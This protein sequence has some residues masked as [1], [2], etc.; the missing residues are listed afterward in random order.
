MAVEEDITDKEREQMRRLAYLQ[1]VALAILVKWGF[2]L[3]VFFLLVFCAFS[4]LIVY[5][6]AKSAQR[7]S[8]ETHLVYNPRQMPK[9]PSIS[10]KQLI[11]NLNLGSIKRQVGERVAMDPGERQCL[12]GDLE[13]KQEKRPS[14]L[15]TLTAYSKSWKGA[16]R[17][18]N[19]YA[20]LLI[21]A[22]EKDRARDLDR[23][24]EAI[25]KDKADKEAQISEL[26]DREHL[27]RANTGVVAPAETLAL[28]TNLISDQ[29]KNMSLIEVQLANEELKKKKLEGIIG[30]DG[31]AIAANIA[32]IRRKIDAIAALGR[33]IDDLRTKYTDAHF[34]VV[35]KMNEKK[36]QEKLL[37]AFLEEK[38]ITN[39][40][41]DTIDRVQKAAEDLVAVEMQIEVLKGN[42]MSLE[43][44]IESNVKRSKEIEVLIPEFSSLK[45]KRVE[46]EEKVRDFDDQLDNISYVKMSAANDLRQIERA[47]GAGDSNPLR[48]KN[49]IIAGGGAVFFT[50]VLA[51][52]VLCLELLFGNVSGGRELRAYDDI[53]YLGSVPAPGQV[54]EQEEKDVLGVVAL[55]FVNASM[56]R[57]TV[58]VCRLK[59]AEPQPRFREALAWSL[60]MSGKKYFTLEIVPSASFEPPEGSEFMLATARKGD[61]GWFAVDN[62]YTLAPTELE[63]LKADI[64]QICADYD[65]VF[66]HQQGGMRRGGSFI[67]QLLEICDSAMIVAGTGK[68]PRSWLAYILKHIREAGKPVMA[69]ATGAKK[70]TVRT[71][72][73]A[74]G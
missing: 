26:E 47:G 58:L 37:A 57:T 40:K 20:Q 29:R 7:F 35:G 10:E 32:T 5:K 56:P 44:D 64:A 38:G 68:S 72:M 4:A 66:I 54:S 21:E 74:K 39:L 25:E 51:F 43:V 17:K 19:A 60:T 30:P 33:E 59:G 73:E 55:K 1:K 48:V 45:H 46:L 52:W 61:K 70:K 63:M 71:E 49:F 67:D 31:I 42:K 18:V 24:S 28:L 27:L 65:H 6:S 36:E 3:L 8:A 2:V 53:L 13:I 15:F 22:Y 14:N 23:H 34:M 9:V 12:V 41:I 62:R 16:V 69:I 11:H 50:L